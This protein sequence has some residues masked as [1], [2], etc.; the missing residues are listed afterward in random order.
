MI[1]TQAEATAIQR[2][3]PD[4]GDKYRNVKRLRLTLVALMRV[5]DYTR[6]LIQVNVSEVSSTSQAMRERDEWKR[7][8]ERSTEAT[9]RAERTLNEIAAGAPESARLVQLEAARTQVEDKL[10][11]VLESHELW[12]QRCLALESKL[13]LLELEAKEQRL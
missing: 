1:Y 9:E 5:A 7:L 13:K 3:V 10:V 11:E 6:S 8:F 4:N 2:M 12:H